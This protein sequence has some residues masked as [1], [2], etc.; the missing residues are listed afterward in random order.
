MNL[1]RAL[2]L[3]TAAALVAGVARGGHELPV[4]PSYYPHEIEIAALAPEQAA[5]R[6]PAGKLHECCLGLAHAPALAAPSS[7]FILVEPVVIAIRVVTDLD[8]L[9]PVGIRD[10]PGQPRAPPLPA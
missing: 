3:T 2:V 8:V 7:V 1:R 5:Q 6:M 4:Y 10:G 9:A